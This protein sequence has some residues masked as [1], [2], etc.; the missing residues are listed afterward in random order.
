M[1]LGLPLDLW[2]G[3]SLGWPWSWGEL[4]VGKVKG[5][6]RENLGRG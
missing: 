1:G 2:L 6:I 4:V 3:G 5:G